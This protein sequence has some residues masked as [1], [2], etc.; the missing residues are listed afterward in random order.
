M[1]GAFETLTGLKNVVGKKVSEVI[2]GIRESD[3][4]L[5][6]IYGRVAL[7]GVPES[8]ETYVD[9][10][11]MW[12]AI[13]VYS[14]GKEH[15]VAVFDVITARKQAEDAL[16]RAKQAAEASR[17]QYE[18]V[19]SLIS[20]V[21]WR[22]EVD[23]RGQFVASYVSPVV[24]WLLGLPA[25]TI[26]DSFDKYFSHVHPQDLPTVQE[27]LSTTLGT[28]AKD[29]PS[30]IDCGNPTVRRSGSVPRGRRTSNSQMDTSSPAAPRSTSPSERGRRGI[31]GQR[32]K[33]SPLRGRFARGDFCRRC[34]GQIRGSQSGRLPDDRLQRGGV[35][36]HEHPGTPGPG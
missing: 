26:G 4:E 7:T 17:A 8:F 27:V 33:V 34:G 32:G 6:E 5:F 13:S 35:A 18:Q 28:L 11:D 3:P 21:V 16:Q 22:Y 1:N 30:N 19:V 24:D 12:Y 2:P 10:L 23:G 15:F 25:G 9:A 31:A 36:R 20:D 14:P 29:G